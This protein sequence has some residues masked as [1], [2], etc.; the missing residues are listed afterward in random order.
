MNIAVTSTNYV[1]SNICGIIDGLLQLGHNVYNLNGPAMNYSASW[2]IPSPD[3]IDI[4]MM[5]DTD[6]Y[7]GLTLTPDKMGPSLRGAKKIICHLHDRWVDYVNAPN[8]P[9]KPVPVEQFRCSTVFVRDL[10]E[11]VYNKCVE[12]GFPVFPIDYSIEQRYVEA[13]AP[14]LSVERK[15][16]L[17]FLG[18]LDTARRR[19]YLDSV[20]S[21]GL[22]VRYGTYEYNDGDGKWSKWIYG[23]YTHDPKYYEE[24]CKYM[25]VFCGFGAGP[26]T[27]RVAEAYAAGCIP[28]I[29][30]YPDD[31]ITY[32]TF[33]DG[34]NCILWETEK[35][36]IE[37]LKYWMNEVKAEELRQRCYEYGQKYMTS[38]FLA[39]YILERIEL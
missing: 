19:F 35:E 13:T 11:S 24:L 22:P 25:F 18:T 17:V 12:K 39:N 10:D 32:R 37:K 15:M 21:A 7:M 31:I 9:I 8:S 6:N 28:V 14:Y 20:R 30:K 2:P 5:M 16:E 38:K 29:Q 36:L 27:M 26:S 23:R 4:W 3:R 34:L 1:D 33:E